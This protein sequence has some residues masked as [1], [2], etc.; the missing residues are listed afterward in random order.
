MLMSVIKTSA[1]A[2]AAASSTPANTSVGDEGT[3]AI[4]KCADLAGRKRAANERILLASARKQLARH[5]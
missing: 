3:D 2:S 1:S 5:A 4:G